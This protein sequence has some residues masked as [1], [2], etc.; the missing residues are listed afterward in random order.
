MSRIQDVIL[1]STRALQPLAVNVS[2]GTL[3]FV[4]DE[5]VIERSN[6]TI[7]QSYS[8]SSGSI[9]PSIIFLPGEDNIN[10][11]MGP[12]GLIGPQGSAGGGGGS[13]SWAL[14]GSSTPTGVN[15]VD[16][17]GLAAYTDIRVVIRGIT[18]AFSDQT[19]L[20][21]SIN[22]GSTFLAASGDYGRINGNGDEI[23]DNSLAFYSGNGTTAKTGEILIEGFNLVNLKISRATIYSLDGINLRVIPTANALNA[24]QVVAL[25]GNNFTAGTIQVFGR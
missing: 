16:F 18:Y 6:G 13:V 7:W 10:D 25:S 2:I 9:N 23:V 22:N 12:P 11:Y 8:G 21:V 15:F 24:V 4:T 19:A 17:I 5:G 1:R 3:Y 20:R 14:V